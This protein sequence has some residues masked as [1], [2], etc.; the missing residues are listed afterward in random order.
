MKSLTDNEIHQRL[1]AARE[2]LGNDEADTIRGDTAL[3]AARK[4]LSGLGLALL[5]AGEQESNRLDGV[6]D[7][8]VL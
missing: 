5:L 8:D 7:L 2:L 3:R 4:V 6:K 1:S